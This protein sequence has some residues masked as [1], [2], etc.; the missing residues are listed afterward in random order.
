[1]SNAGSLQNRI[2]GRFLA[3]V[4]ADKDLPEQAAARLKTVL[5]A[6]DAATA[7]QILEALEAHDGIPDQHSAD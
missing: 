5:G 4:V 6:K 1:M 3:A 7:N 2:V